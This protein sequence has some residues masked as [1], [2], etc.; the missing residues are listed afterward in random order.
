MMLITH[1]LGVVGE[2]CDHVAV[3]YAGEIVEKGELE[4]IF[5]RPKHPYT[6]GLFQ[7]I[8]DIEE[9][10]SVIRPILGLMPDPFNLPS[11]CPFHP[12]CPECLEVCRT[13]PPPSCERDGHF[14]LCHLHAEGGT[15]G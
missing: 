15:R 6:R 14:V 11:G 3:M 2:V 9:E 8:P 4:Q 12:R 1:D 5:D 10:N 7:C 13:V